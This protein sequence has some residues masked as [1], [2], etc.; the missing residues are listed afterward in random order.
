MLRANPQPRNC[1]QTHQSSSPQPAANYAA[2]LTMPL[3]RLGGLAFLLFC[4]SLGSA[5]PRA[6]IVVGL[7]AGELAERRLQETAGQLHRGFSARGL[8]ESAI[9]TLGTTGVPV[10]RDA[11]LQALVPTE[12]PAE[13]TWIVLLGTGAAGRNG[14]PAFQVSG[15]RFTAEDLR[16]A[17]STLQGHK[18]VVV[19]TSQ[20]GGFLPPLAELANVDA[21]AATAASG[22]LSEPRFGEA[23]AAA[24]LVA[25]TA[26]FATL[27]REATK[28][29]QAL[30]AGQGLAQLEH[31]AQWDAPTHQLVRLADKTASPASPAAAT[32]PALV[33]PEASVADLALP[34]PTPNDGVTRLPATDESRRLVAA[35]HAQAAASEYAAV[36]LHAEDHVVVDAAGHSRYTH[37]AQTLV[38]TGEAIDQVA[39]LRL[40]YEPPHKISRLRRA[41]IIQPDGAQIVVEPPAQAPAAPGTDRRWG[42]ATNGLIEL[43]EVVTGS[44]VEIDCSIETSAEDQA[45]EFYQEWALIEAYPT[46]V[47]EFRCTLPAGEK[48]HWFAPNL[49]PPT[50]T[51]TASGARELT[52]ALKDIAPAEPQIGD[53]PPR[54]WLPW[55]GVS[56]TASWDDFAAWY[57]RIAGDA[58]TAG[59]LTTALAQ[60]LRQQHP[61]RLGLIRAAYERV[62]ALRYVAIELGVGGF[63]P[64]LPDQVLGRR[65]GDCKDKANLLAT[66]LQTAGIAAD[67]ALVNRTDTTFV[68]FAGSQFNHALVRVPAAPDQ[69]QPHEIWLDATDRLVSFGS[70]PY[71]DLGR[72]ALILGERGKPV[73]ATITAALEPPTLWLE[74]WHLAPATT[75]A[76]RRAHLVLTGEGTA[77]ELLRSSFAGLSPTG[78][79]ARLKTLLA[80]AHPALSVESVTAT[81]AFD[82]RTAFRV[83]A[84]LELVGPPL[85]AAAPPNWDSIFAAAHRDRPLL[86]KEGRPWTYRQIL[87]TGTAAGPEATAATAAPVTVAGITF[88]RQ[89]EGDRRVTEIRSPGGVIAPADYP[90]LRATWFRFLTQP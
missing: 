47:R 82:L 56:A 32:K 80:A 78:R 62:A 40:P 55:V 12:V 13:E 58:M 73:F 19:A 31:A 76:P 63:R 60:T 84:E 8:A 18:N 28:R 44:I 85:P 53:N 15:P 3:F 1:A 61:D 11:I 25:P 89:Q 43:P 54:T 14:L 70:I 51:K 24:L 26:D 27:A 34:P 86:L 77:D 68:D 35:A 7:A 46:L 59:P 38:R 64:R 72:P 22:E 16:T 6:V 87:H 2:A 30:Y 74:E 17:L 81:D 4:A 52:W 20:S 42:D 29:V 71:G 75:G 9:V 23:W 69:G 65:F 88:S 48:W 49:A 21:V 79:A 67:F 45:G 41:R 39:S 90:A 36:V 57:R 66:L 50:E 5:A 37:R 10:R 33:L 83:E